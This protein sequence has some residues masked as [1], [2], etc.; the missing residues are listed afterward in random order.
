MVAIVALTSC[1]SGV[2]GTS[3]NPSGSASSV[4]K[5]I[6]PLTGASFDVTSNKWVSGP[7]IMAKIDNVADA[8]PQAGLN[9]TDV[10]FDEMVEGG[11]TRLLAVWQSNMPSVLG[12]V[13]SVRPMDPDIASPFGGI[14][15]FSGGQAAFVKAMAESPVFSA[16]E[17]NQQGKHTFKRVTD[18]FAP[19]NVMISAQH[20]QAQHLDLAA[21]KSPFTFASSAAEASAA[22]AGVSVTELTVKFPSAT[23]NWSWSASKQVWLRVQDGKPH[24]DANDKT[25]I[26]AVNVVVIPVTIDRSYTDPRYGFVPRSLL[27][28][29]GTAYIFSGGKMLKATYKKADKASPIQLF[30]SAGNPVKLAVGNTWFELQP[31]DVGSLSMVYPAK[32]T[33]SPSATK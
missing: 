4:Q 8:R 19:H 28:G 23:A 29:S 15:C 2:V 12:P 24:L 20:L 33:P 17:T 10:V 9:S 5:V 32:P 6:A 14:I 16:T 11:L 3:S 25:Q 13:R 26:Q 27:V 1:A 7:A 31:K 21:P 22:V 30:D 18:R